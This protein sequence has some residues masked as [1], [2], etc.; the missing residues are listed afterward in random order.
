M[1]VNMHEAKSQLSRLVELVL[2]GEEVIIARAGKPVAKLVPYRK[3]RRR[4]PGRLKGQIEI[5]PDFDD[6][7]EGITK[8][9]EDRDEGLSS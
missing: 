2:K 4:V 9:F 8:M 7:S 5:A 3:D 6:S 1:Q